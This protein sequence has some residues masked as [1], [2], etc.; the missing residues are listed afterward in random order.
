[1]STNPPP[2][3][4]AAL[5]RI[6]HELGTIRAEFGQ[7]RDQGDHRH[8][9]LLKELAEVRVEARRASE[10]AADAKRLADAAAHEMHETQAAVI[11][12]TKGLVDRQEEQATQI[13]DLVAE[14]STQ[15]VALNR[16]VAAETDRVTR[17]DERKKV[18]DAR[19]TKLGR[20]WP[21]LLAIA[22]VASYA[23]GHW[24]P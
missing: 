16:L 5:E 7:F 6:L 8:H 14:T 11:A 1:M 21:L 3:T 13:A 12:H 17:E 2:S 4:D 10:I 15:T 19:W 24:K 23:A 20:F 22:S 18:D 9:L